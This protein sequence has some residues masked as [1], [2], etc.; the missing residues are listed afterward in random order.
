MF[1]KLLRPRGNLQGKDLIHDVDQEVSSDNDN[2]G[3][4]NDSESED[5]GETVLSEDDDSE[6][7]PFV[8]K[9]GLSGLGDLHKARN[10]QTKEL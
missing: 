6:E 2:E 8:W 9:Y 10:T 7:P 3:L 4:G 1:E 5:T